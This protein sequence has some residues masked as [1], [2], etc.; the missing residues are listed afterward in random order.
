MKVTEKFIHQFSSSLFSNLSVEK[1][2]VLQF[3]IKSRKL[4]F[5]LKDLTLL[6]FLRLRI[7]NSLSTVIKCHSSY[8]IRKGVLQ[9]YQVL[10]YGKTY[11]RNSHFVTTNF[12]DKI[13]IVEFCDCHTVT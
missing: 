1:L 11:Q 6:I 13:M 7:G 2:L 3:S 8:V 9:N 4:T 5:C 10:V 12:C